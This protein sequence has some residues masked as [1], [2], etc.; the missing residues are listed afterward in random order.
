MPWVKTGEVNGR[1]IYETEELVTEKGI[2]SSKLKTF[3]KGTVLIAMYGQGKTRGQIGRLGVDATVNQACAA[4]VAKEGLSSKFLF[5]QLKLS[6]DRLRNLGQ[7]GNQ[8]NL[9]SGLVKAFEI[10]VPPI[11]MQKEF[12]KQIQSL[13][14]LKRQFFDTAD[15]MNALFASLQ[16]RAFRGGL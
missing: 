12:V 16:Q 5:E 14:L 4:L 2:R 9:N 8:P 1:E 7:G 3:P 6:Y 11:E 10:I 13:D 15:K